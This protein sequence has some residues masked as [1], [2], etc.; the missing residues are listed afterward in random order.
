MPLQG[1]AA[2]LARRLDAIES[3]QPHVHEHER[4][5][6]LLVARQG[7]LAGSHLHQAQPKGGQ[8]TLQRLEVRWMVVHQQ[9]P[10]VLFCNPCAH[11]ASLDS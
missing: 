1:Q 2:Q 4:E 7:L 3:R 9:D 10:D 11:D 8:V 6:L 5:F